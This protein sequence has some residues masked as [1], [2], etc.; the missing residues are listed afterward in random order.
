M[1][2]IVKKAEEIRNQAAQLRR[3]AELLHRDFSLI[4][5]KMKLMEK[6]GRVVHVII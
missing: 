1:N 2:E 5:E 6:H 4:L 3:R